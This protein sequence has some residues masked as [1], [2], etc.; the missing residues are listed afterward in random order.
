M[1]LLVSIS[2]PL[3]HNNN[4]MQWEWLN[5]QW[6]SKKITSS[7]SPVK[8]WSFFTN[9]IAVTIAATIVTI[10]L[11]RR[12]YVRLSFSALSSF[13][14]VTDVMNAMNNTAQVYPFSTY[15]KFSEKLTFYP[16]IRRRRC[17]YQG[18]RNVS[19]P[20]NFTEM[21]HPIQ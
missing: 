1:H 18:E 6:V 19:F 14:S 4:C 9:I 3:Q 17:A 16:M 10:V 5:G 13:W 11:Y 8:P 7:F 2:Y 15:A 20:E 21:D 12:S